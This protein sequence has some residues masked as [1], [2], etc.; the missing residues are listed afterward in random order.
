MAVKRICPRCVSEDDRPPAM[1]RVDSSLI[2]P[3]CG[4]KEALQTAVEHGIM[5]EAQMEEILGA[6]KEAESGGTG[7]KQQVRL[8]DRTGT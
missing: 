4:Y 7:R 2:C 5:D 6:I 8:H 3:M 1:S